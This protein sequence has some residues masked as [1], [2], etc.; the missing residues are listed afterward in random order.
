[1]AETPESQ[2]ALMFA[3]YEGLRR[4]GPG[5]EAS[6]LKALSLLPELPP[7]ARIVDF[8]CGA[9]AASLVLAGV[10]EHHVTAVD[11][12]QP[13][14]EELDAHARRAG[15]TERIETVQ[16]DMGDPP[17]PRGAF[18][19]VWSEGAIY[20]LGFEQGL[21]AWRR[22]L[23]PG[24]CVAVTEVTWLTDEPPREVAEFWTTGYPAMSSIDE[25]LARVRCAGFEP[26]GHF[27]LPP[28][29]WQN[30]YGPLAAR[31]AAFRAEHAG[32]VA[33]EELLE[34]V[35]REIDI[36][37]QYG[38]SYGYVFYLGTVVD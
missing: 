32:R 31:V 5:S 3:F 4:K 20:N 19:V 36:W 15:L 22:V 30:Y 24:G 6:T 7:A 10:A 25:N 9:G 14:L 1:M 38:H 23:A 16:A 33:A 28:E 21:R 11:I 13:F 29:D 26:A 8:G 2:L 35:Q 12:H 18:D 37:Q 17:F 27:V 34:G